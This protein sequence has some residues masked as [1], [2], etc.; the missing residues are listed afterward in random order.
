MILHYFIF[1]I[2]TALHVSWISDNV[3]TCPRYQEAEAEKKH[4]KNILRISRQACV[5][6]SLSVKD[7]ETS[8]KC[9]PCTK[10]SNEAKFNH[11]V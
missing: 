1:I 7:Y 11:V 4:E 9:F 10:R 3:I 6:I 8:R 5:S 2:E